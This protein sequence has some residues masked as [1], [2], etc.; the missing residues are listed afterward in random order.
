MH[1]EPAYPSRLHRRQEPAVIPKIEG[2]SRWGVGGRIMYIVLTHRAALLAS[3]AASS[4]SRKS[5]EDSP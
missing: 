5:G 2:E 3:A 4:R 1:G